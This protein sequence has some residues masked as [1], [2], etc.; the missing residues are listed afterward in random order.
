MLSGDLLVETKSV[1]QSI[2]YLSAKTYFLTLPSS[3]LPHKSLDSSRC[4]ISEPDLLCTSEAEIPW[5]IFRSGCNSEARKSI[6]LQLSQIFAQAAKPSAISTT[7]EIDP[8]I[9]NIICTP[10]QSVKPISSANQM[11]STTT[12]PV[13]STA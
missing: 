10:L 3:L 8:N 1:I 13:V 5:G 7:T 12:V 6:E 11:P 9:T 4:V 2:S